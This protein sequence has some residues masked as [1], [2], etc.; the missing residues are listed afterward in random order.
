M[1]LTRPQFHRWLALS[2]IVFA[3]GA[4]LSLTYPIEELS[5]RLNDLYFRLRG[6]QPTSQQV[7]LVV[8]D[9]A[10]ISRYGRWPWSRI[11]LA[12]LVRAASA[13]GPL[14]LGLDII[15]SEPQE[16]AADS[17]LGE[18]LGSAGNVVL[19]TKIAASPEHSVWVEPLP[20]FARRAA[21]IGHVHAVL[22]PDG[23]CRSVPAR[24]M[25]LEG[26]R[27]ALALEVVRVA[28]GVV[29]QDVPDSNRIADGNLATSA[30]NANLDKV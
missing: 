7:A 25:T 23:I 30:R 6:T 29:F 21:G 12:R 27:R 11:L 17:D 16:E 15:L 9:D 18:A 20:L 2:A 19:A 4:V 5:R 22:G 14:A 24:E 13:Q 8:I 10:S 28:R 3:L 1:G 26:P